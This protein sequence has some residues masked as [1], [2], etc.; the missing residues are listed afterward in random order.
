VPIHLHLQFIEKGDLSPA[1]EESLGKIKQKLGEYK[2]QLDGI[3][4][5]A[6][7]V[8][9]SRVIN[10]KAFKVKA[11]IEESIE[12]LQILA[13]NRRINIVTEPID[14]NLTL[15]ADGELVNS[16]IYQ[17]VHNAVKFNRPGGAVQVRITPEDGAML[18]QITD[19]GEGIPEAVMKRFGEDFNQTVEAMKRGVEGLGLGLALSNYVAAVHGGKLTAQRGPGDKGTLVQ[20]RL[21]NRG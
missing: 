7:L 20:L 9:Q 17:L 18:F 1:Q 12:P 10:P 15:V 5:Y 2:S 14:P 19:D 16:A 3:I 21:P 6:M 11:L 13:T 8:S 4:K